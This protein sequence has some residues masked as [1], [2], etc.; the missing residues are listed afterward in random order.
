VVNANR[1]THHHLGR[2]D[3]LLHFPD[4]DGFDHRHQVAG[5]KALNKPLGIAAAVRQSGKERLR[6]LVC[7]YGVGLFKEYLADALVVHGFRGEWS[8][9]RS[10]RDCG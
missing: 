8:Q 6:R 7:R 2:I 4:A 5:G 1:S 3:V 9:A 10:T